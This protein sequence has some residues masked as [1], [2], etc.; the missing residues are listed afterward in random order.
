MIFHE[1]LRGKTEIG[2]WSMKML[3]SMFCEEAESVHNSCVPRLWLRRAN[4]ADTRRLR[5]T[6]KDR[7][8]RCSLS[9]G[10]LTS[11]G[12]PKVWDLHR[13]WSMKML[14]SMFCEE[15]ESVHNSCVPRLWLRRANQADTRRLRE[16]EKDRKARCS[17][18]HGPLTSNGTPKVWDLHN[19]IYICGGQGGRNNYVVSSTVF[20]VGTWRWGVGTCGNRES[21]RG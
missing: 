12:T 18:S 5:E 2:K 21:A 16:T 3:D 20:S 14:D 8:A 10:P 1:V 6:E 17:L 19:K 15:A 9:H 4:Q 7:K 13:K 11:N